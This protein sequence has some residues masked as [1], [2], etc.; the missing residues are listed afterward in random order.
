MYEIV[1]RNQ[2]LQQILLPSQLLAGINNIQSSQYETLKDHTMPCFV[3]PV[4]LR[5]PPNY[6]EICSKQ[7]FKTNQFFWYFYLNNG[8]S[9]CCILS[10]RFGSDNLNNEYGGFCILIIIAKYGAVIVLTIS[11]KKT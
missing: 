9:D 4:L 5:L 8:A 11:Q 7:N 6:Q 3:A 10:E 1:H 2:H